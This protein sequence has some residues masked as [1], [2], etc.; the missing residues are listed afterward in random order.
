MRAPGE[1]L[2]HGERIGAV[3]RLAERH[4]ILHHQR[5]RPQH[6][7]QRTAGRRAVDRARLR[8]REPRGA[9]R[10][11]LTGELPLIDIGSLHHVRDADLVQQFAPPRRA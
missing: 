7:Q 1:L 10:R 6:R 5:V 2:Q 11:A 4:A 9:G 8:H 3:A